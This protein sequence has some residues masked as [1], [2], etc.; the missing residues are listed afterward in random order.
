MKLAR[1]RD[2]E[3]IQYEEDQ[4]AAQEKEEYLNM[5][6]NYERH[7]P[8]FHI[9][10]PDTESETAV[11]QRRRLEYFGP[12]EH[13]PAQRVA[14]LLNKKLNGDDQLKIGES[15]MNFTTQLVGGLLESSNTSRYGMLT[16]PAI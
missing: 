4:Q 1:R 10:T 15:V 11:N 13:L 16:Q 6:E 7:H 14:T 3:A 8:R 2:R 9:C 12:M 5:M